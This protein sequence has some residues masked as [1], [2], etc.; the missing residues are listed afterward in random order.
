[1][2]GARTAR[3]YC[4]GRVRRAACRLGTATVACRTLAGVCLELLRA[5]R[6]AHRAGS[7]PSRLSSCQSCANPP[8]PFSFPRVVFFCFGAFSSRARLWWAALGT[9]IAGFVSTVAAKTKDET[10]KEKSCTWYDG[11][12]YY[13]GFIG[14]S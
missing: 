4:A 9:V 14:F 8:H 2:D 3:R 13:E 6:I 10:T 1:M 11:T 12:T 7:A 5:P